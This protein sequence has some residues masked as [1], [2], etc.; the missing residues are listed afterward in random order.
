MYDPVDRKYPEEAHP[1]RQK[2]DCGCQG[3]GGRQE[4]RVIVTRYILGW[5]NHFGTRQRWLFHNIRIL[6]NTTE[7]FPLTQLILYYGSFTSIDLFLISPLFK[8]SSIG[9]LVTGRLR[10]ESHLCLGPAVWQVLGPTLTSHLTFL[11]LSFLIGKARKMQWVH[12]ILVKTLARIKCCLIKCYFI[13]PP[14]GF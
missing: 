7:L 2:A 10:F 11:G 13:W 14:F 3:L 9:A 5:W 1:Q 8:K 12:Q 4:S 6:L